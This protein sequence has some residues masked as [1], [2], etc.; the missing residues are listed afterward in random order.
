VTVAAQVALAAAL[1]TGGAL[2]GLSLYRLLATDPG[3]STS[4]VAAVRVSAYAARYPTMESVRMFFD[5]VVSGVAALPAV[6]SAAAG[7]SLPLS[8]QTS[9][10]SVQAEGQ[11]ILPG[12]RPAAGWQFVSPGYFSSLGMAIEHGRDFTPDDLAHDGHVTVVNEALARVLFGNRDPIGQRI[13]VG[14]GDATGDWHEVI[15]VVADVRHHA[16]D[17]AAVPRVYDLFGEHWGRTLFVVARSRGV[18]ASG[19]IPSIRRTV[20]ALDVEAPVFEA[21]TVETLI[22]RSAGPRRLS[23]VLAVLMS[24]AAVLLAIVGVYAA[25]SAAVAERTREMGI[26]AALGAAPSGLRRLVL[27]DGAM[28]AAA[29]AAG[30]VAGSVIAARLLSAQL[31]G[32]AN[33]DVVVLIPVVTTLL[34]LVAISAVLPAAYRAARVHPLIAIR[35]E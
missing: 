10:T 12:S 8:G 19:L 5:S 35:A 17:Q 11:S 14:G 9:G 21:A 2:L 27:R 30:G 32:V 33:R 29:G 15:G 3:F 24:A 7:S 1:S 26:R 25:A 18:D 31:F 4:G 28:V 16:L 22:A 20:H 34:A 23:A 6:S 13:A